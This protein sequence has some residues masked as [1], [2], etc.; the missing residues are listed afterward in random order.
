M[1]RRHVVL[2]ADAIEFF[3]QQCKDKLRGAPLFTEDGET[4]WR[5]HVWARAV[6]AAIKNHNRDAGVKRRISRHITAYSFR[7]AHISQLLQIYGVDPLMVSAQTG[8][9]IAMTEKAYTVY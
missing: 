2:S 8:N 9:S 1:R 5:R 4:P 6:Q 7:H 3:N